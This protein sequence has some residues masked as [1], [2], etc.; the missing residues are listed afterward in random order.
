MLGD[1]STVKP[2][3]SDPQKNSYSGQLVFVLKIIEEF[4]VH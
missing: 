2:G 1:P 3:S 4:K